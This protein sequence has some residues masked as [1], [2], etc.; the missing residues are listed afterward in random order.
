MK[1][2]LRINQKQIENNKKKKLQQ[3]TDWE[4]DKITL[5]GY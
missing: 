3:S 5:S 1:S 4:L 2:E